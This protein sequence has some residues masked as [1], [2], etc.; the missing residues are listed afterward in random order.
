MVMGLTG[1]SSVLDGKKGLKKYQKIVSTLK[2]TLLKAV[3]FKMSWT[4]KVTAEGSLSI[5]V[6]L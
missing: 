3:S 2:V 1:C 4:L 6:A 5:C